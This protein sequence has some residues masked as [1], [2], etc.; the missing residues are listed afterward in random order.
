MQLNTI[1]RYGIIGGLF[2]VPFLPFVITSSM[3]FPFISGKNFLFRALMEIVAGLWIVLALRDSAYRPRPSVLL[4]SLL[5]FLSVVGL[6]DLL[7]VYPHK[8]FW[9][10]IE[11]MEGYIGLFH[12][13]LFFLVGT[14][15]LTPLLWRRFFLTSI[16]AS[17]LMALYTFLQLGGAVVINQGGVRI[18][19]TL[20]NATY[21][22]GYMLMHLFIT[23]Y[24][25]LR[26]ETQRLLRVA[27]GI[28]L[29]F[30]AIVLYY[31]ATRGALIAALGGALLFALLVVVF[32]KEHR[33]LRAMS[34]GIIAAVV[35][36]VGTFFALKDTSLVR[37]S[38]VLSRFASLTAQG[39][40]LSRTLVWNMAL[41]GA[42]ERPIL[43]WGQENFNYVFNKNYDPKLYAQEAWFDRVHNI[44]L[45]WLIAAGA[46]GLIAYL[47]L[48]AAGAYLLWRRGSPFTLLEKSAFSAFFASYLFHNLFVF[49]NLISYVLF[50]AVLGYLHA[51]STEE[52]APLFE[53]KIPGAL[54]QNA[55]IAAVAIVVAGSLYVY[56]IR[57]VRAAQELIVA[58]SGRL[59]NQADVL[60]RFRSALAYDTLANSEIREQLIQYANNLAPTNAPLDAKQAFYTAARAEALKEI[61]ETPEDARARLSFVTLLSSFQQYAEELQ[62]LAIAEKLTPRKQP[63]L[64]EE[65]TVYLNT[66]QYAKAREV[67]KEAFELEPRFDDARLIYATGAIYAGDVKLLEELLLPR[68]GTTLVFDQRILRAY[69][70]S[71]EYEK[72]AA[73]WQKKIAEDPENASYHVSLGA[74]YL[75]LGRRAEAITEIEKAI[76]LNPAFKVQGEFYINEI[77]AGRNP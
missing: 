30:Q 48:Y 43:G 6:A 16:G 52:K 72:V 20:G 35:L 40:L 66:K 18:D 74:A 8:S 64:F 32:G 61:A 38:Q 47:S 67:F 39:G 49:D 10:N 57:P 53:Y 5:A 13:F 41:K 73:I 15:V 69:A 26:R 22:A 11:R 17:V 62:Q 27:L 70:G 29:L 46:L 56:N 55:I 31:T 42:A 7:G 44:F 33:R 71:G 54:F 51:R 45:D 60:E 12:L 36:L 75:L 21:L 25:L 63:V 24:L 28:A 9:S 19:G 2:V 23:L 3:F 58:I 37:D 76:E 50:F 59:T 14:S 77:R 1:L 65:G 34:L 4:F 68:Y